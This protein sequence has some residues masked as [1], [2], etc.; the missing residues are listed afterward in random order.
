A[1]TYRNSGFSAISLILPSKPHI[2]HGRDSEL[3]NIVRILRKDEARV[4]VLGPGGI[5]KTCL[6]RAVLHHN[7]IT[8]KYPQ[9][10]FVSCESTATAADIQNVVASAL[11]LEPSGKPLSAIIRCLSAKN[12]SLLVLDNFETPWEPGETRSEVEGFLSLLADI[13]HVALLV[14]MRGQERPS[15]I[16]WTRP[17]VAP[18]EPL[19]STAARKTF[20]D[21][22]DTSEDD[23]DTIEQLLGLTGY[24]PLAITLM[25]TLAAFEGCGAVLSR[26]ESENVSLLSE[27]YDKE[28]NRETSLRMSL[29]SPRMAPAAL[30][31]LSLLSL[32]PDG[33]LDV[34]LFQC[35]TPISDLPRCKT[36]LLRTS[37]A[38]VG[39]DSMLK[40]LTPVR[41]FIRKTYPPSMTIA[42]GLRL[43]WDQLLVL[44]RTYKMPSGDLVNRLAAN[45]G[46]ITSLLKYG[47]ETEGPDLKG[48]VFGIFYLSAFTSFM[49]GTSSPLMANIAEWVDH[50]DDP[51]LRAYYIS[52][53][54]NQGARISRAN[55]PALIAQG[56]A[57]LQ[58]GND[59]VEEAQFRKTV[60]TYY[61]RLNDP[62]TALIHCRIA[63]SLAE[64]AG[65]NVQ[66]YESTWMM[67][68][69]TNTMGNFSKGLVFARKA[70]QIAG[71]IG[72]FQRETTAMKEEAKAW[73][74]LGNLTRGIELCNEAR[75]LLTASG[76]ADRG[77]LKFLDMEA[78]IRLIKTEYV[79]SR[80]L[81][82]IIVRTT[83]MDNWALFHANCLANI[84]S[85]DIAV[86]AINSE[87][88][89]LASLT[90]TRDIFSTRY[91]RGLLMCDR[92]LAD[93]YVHTGRK[94]DARNLYEKCIRSSR[95]ASVSVMSAS[96][97]KLG[98]LSL[99]LCDTQATIRWAT[100]CFAFGKTTGSLLLVSWAFR[101]LGD[102]FL[103][104]GDE[105]TAMVVF[106]VAMDEFTRMDVHQ[107]KGECLLRF[108]EISK[109]HGNETVA[110][111]HL[112]QA[113]RMF[114]K[115]GL[116]IVATQISE[117]ERD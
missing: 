82:D 13:R 48:V 49:F 55:A 42:R 75:Q 112:A 108:A 12:A 114:E 4:A 21:I 46:N 70:Q 101:L 60:A 107:G 5:G 23:N 93:F 40:V 8:E 61:F 30:Q 94:S 96:L 68:T 92:I 62:K 1:R 11:G 77:E 29:S 43:H 66:K 98:D 102:I 15:N 63:Q 53:R 51:K 67:A 85:I 116:T 109:R 9:R 111:Q 59:I 2:F 26:W 3:N 38:Y 41:E 64:K 115:S 54:F 95:G 37:L 72:N 16:R 27:G 76:L 83:S 19:I 100:T 71:T 33:V 45:I 81:N 31:L 105:E 32:L 24:L 106:Q 104:Q 113:R 39:S 56:T 79:E 90:R 99:G 73:A 80:T 17:F 52:W 78:D 65:D 91:P 88:S 50:V 44:W 89:G 69:I 103:A 7:D 36:T 117:R 84:V 58:L 34:D 97:R 18:L 35:A 86:G 74:G 22:A 28:T 87:E 6:A 47:L 14:T 110:T 10:Y 25:A 20:D 57:Y